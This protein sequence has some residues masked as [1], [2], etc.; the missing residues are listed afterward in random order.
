MLE[1]RIRRAQDGYYQEVASAIN[2][3]PVLSKMNIPISSPVPESAE[4]FA[5]MTSA[6]SSSTMSKKLIFIVSVILIA[7]LA[8]YTLRKKD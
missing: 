3:S 5:F 7:S 2:A 8:F 6:S 1:D 4:G